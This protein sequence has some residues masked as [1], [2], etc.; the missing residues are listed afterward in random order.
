MSNAWSRRPGETDEQLEA[1]REKIRAR[2][3]VVNL[4]PE[5]LEK[6]RVENR[7]WQRKRREDPANREK[8]RARDPRRWAD[9]VKRE[10]ANERRRRKPPPGHPGLCELCGNPGKPIRGGVGLNKDHRHDNGFVRG[11][12]CTGCN[13]RVAVLDLRFEDPEYF[14]KLEAWSNRGANQE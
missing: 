12:I 14:K 10:E 13:T 3:R 8:D 4:S 11:W 1:R 9:P 5:A 2:R 6:A 7:E